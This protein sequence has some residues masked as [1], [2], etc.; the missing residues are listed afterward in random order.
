MMSVTSSPRLCVLAILIGT[1]ACSREDKQLTV[2]GVTYSF[3]SN[4]VQSFTEPGDGLPFA[5]VRPG[6]Q[7]FDL[8]YSE[9]AKYRR[10]WLGGG[11]PLI[12]SVNDHRSRQFERF[13][14]D[15]FEV[16]CRAEQPYYSCG[17]HL[18]DRGV[19]WTIVFNRDQLAD[20]DAIR[21]SAIGALRKYGS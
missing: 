21:A 17:M 14:F 12:T 8:I 15:G 7:L 2:G 6:G 10:N 19:P 20:A 3:P 18:E 1:S 9:R 4:R 13:N 11:S 16:V 5:R